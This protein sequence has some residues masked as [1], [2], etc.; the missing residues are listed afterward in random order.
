MFH[1]R[2]DKLTV[3]DLERAM[4][5]YNMDVGIDITVQCRNCWDT[6]TGLLS[7]LCQQRERSRKSK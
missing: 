5:N 3:S 6:I 7:A 1:C 4:R 2:R